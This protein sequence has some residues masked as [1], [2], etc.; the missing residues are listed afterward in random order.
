MNKS[1]YKKRGDRFEKRKAEK[2]KNDC[3]GNL[4]PLSFRKAGELLSP[5][6]SRVKIFTFPP[7]AVA[8]SSGVNDARPKRVSQLGEKCVDETKI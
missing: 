3:Q 6:Q 1:Q 8:Q 2:S 5:G 7:Y 4:S